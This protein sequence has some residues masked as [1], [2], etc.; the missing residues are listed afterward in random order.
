MLAG[1]SWGAGIVSKF[2]SAFHRY[3]FDPDPV[4][5]RVE[6]ILRELAPAQSPD[7]GFAVHRA[8]RHVQGTLN[9][10]RHFPRR[11]LAL[12]Q[13]KLYEPAADWWQ[14]GSGTP[15]GSY[16]II[17]E[18]E[19]VLEAVSDPAGSRMLWYHLDEGQFVVSNS[20]RAITMYIG[21]F[22]FEP[23]VV[24]WLVSTGTRGPGQ[25][26]S[27]HLRLIPPSGIARL[28]KAAWTLNV[29][30]PPI[31]F[32]E[33]PRDRE[34]HLAALEAALSETFAAFGETDAEHSILALSGG[35]DSRALAAFLGRPPGH[36][37]RSFTGGTTEAAGLA[38]SDVAIGA[39][40]AAA[41]GFDHRLIAARAAAPEQVETLLERFVVASEGRHDHLNRLD[42]GYDSYGELYMGG[43]DTIVRGD[44]GFGW[45]PVRQTPTAVRRSVGIPLCGEIGALKPH[46]KRFG[47][48]HHA[49]PPDLERQPDESFDTWRD[50]LYHGFRIPTVLAALNESK[51]GHFDVVN[52]LVSRRA[53]EAARSLPDDL[54]TDKPLFREL[55]TRIGPDVPFAGREGAPERLDNLRRPDVHRLLRASLASDTA[56]RCFGRPL[57]TWV[58]A[59]IQPWRAFASSAS[60]V[61]IGRLRRLG[62]APDEEVRVAPLRI[63]FRLYVAATMIDRLEADAAR[64]T[65]DATPAAARREAEPATT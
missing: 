6:A 53:L 57:A 37:W 27:R 4:Q 23:A 47:L 54:R 50:R 31:R 24:P 18:D 60:R 49:L 40:V 15:D 46:L 19:D 62:R 9:L 52:P 32:A 39:R 56:I 45:K 48:D 26:Y 34:E 35:T 38:R 20:E 65:G 28:D 58:R 63:A 25:S 3:G 42:A 17:R 59:E 7:Q 12:C 22:D 55:V 64:F 44:E 61:L 41:L 33:V 36:R 13:G 14:P 43:I 51:A 10:S 2:I 11:G 8:D 5:R 21:R 16:A 29:S 30:A 1:R